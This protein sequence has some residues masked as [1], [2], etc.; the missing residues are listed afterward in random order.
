[1]SV[2]PRVSLQMI[3]TDS[4]KHVCPYCQNSSFRRSH[5]GGLRQHVVSL[6]GI[7]PYRCLNCQE[8]FWKISERVL[9]GIWAGIIGFLLSILM[10]DVVF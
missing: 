3:M 2:S 8:R 4:S 10:S 9:R 7:R 5:R 6:V 1:M